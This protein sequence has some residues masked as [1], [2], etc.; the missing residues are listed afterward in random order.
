MRVTIGSRPGASGTRISPVGL[1]S[2][3]TIPLGAESPIF[4]ATSS[5]PSGVPRLPGAEAAQVLRIA[6]EALGN[7]VRHSGAKHIK[8]RFDGRVLLV[9]DDGSGFDAGAV[10]GKRLGLTSMAER[11]TELGAKLTIDSTDAGTTVRLELPA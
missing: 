5:S 3:K 9:S 11:A 8:V 6:Q 2:L 4:F 7:A 10:R 1:R